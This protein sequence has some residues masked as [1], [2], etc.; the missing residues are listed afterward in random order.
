MNVHG[1]DQIFEYLSI[2]W[3]LNSTGQST[4]SKQT[5]ELTQH[6][7]SVTQQ[8]RN[9][10]RQ[11]L[12]F[13]LFFKSL[14]N[15]NHREFLNSL[16]GSSACHWF[17]PHLNDFHVAP[18]KQLKDSLES[19]RQKIEDFLMSIRRDKDKMDTIKVHSCRE[20]KGWQHWKDKNPPV[21]LMAVCWM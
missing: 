4:S 3:Q 1:V 14:Y 11:S 15:R 19:H 21:H 18:Q 10:S 2:K 8:K 20:L 17:C 16:H 5:I 7:K 13:V 9:I 12:F 6:R